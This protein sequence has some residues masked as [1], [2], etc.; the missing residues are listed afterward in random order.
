MNIPNILTIFRIVLIPVFI[1]LFFSDFDN[2]LTWA[3]IVFAVA[4]IT[5]ILDGFIARKYNLVSDLG[6]V[7][8][9]LADKLMLMTVLICL[10]SMKLVPLWLLI[11]MMIK[12]AVMVYG[13][14]R[15]YFSKEQVIIPSNRYGK[16]ATVSFYLA[17]C[18]VLLR[19]ENVFATIILYFAVGLA[20][21]AFFNYVKIA[22]QSK[23]KEN[24]Q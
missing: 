12:E 15:L 7:L 20:V 6:K 17:I 9:P 16:L 19:I 1:F 2:N 3:L 23:S 24:S 13:G 5:D 21:F 14:I 8:D 18:L 10:A 11:L 22:I 4:G